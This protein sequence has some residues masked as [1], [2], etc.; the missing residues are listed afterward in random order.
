M[1]KGWG[2]NVL[3]LY[4]DSNLPLAKIN[5]ISVVVFGPGLNQPKSDEVLAL[6]ILMIIWTPTFKCNQARNNDG[7]MNVFFEDKKNPRFKSHVKLINWSSA[8]AQHFLYTR[9][10][11]WPCAGIPALRVFRGER[12]PEQV[13]QGQWADNG[14]VWYPFRCSETWSLIWFQQHGHPVRLRFCVFCPFKWRQ[15]FVY[16]HHVVLTTWWSVHW[17]KPHEFSSYVWGGVDASQFQ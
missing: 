17:Y 5:D 12:Q 15:R 13:R 7:I 6:C 11:P 2:P 10:L 8:S 4:V 1:S 9:Y 16:C 14:I 3:S